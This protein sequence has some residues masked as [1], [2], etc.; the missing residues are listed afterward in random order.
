LFI[1]TGDMPARLIDPQIA[2]ND[3]RERHLAQIGMS[4]RDATH[5]P[6]SV[7]SPARRVAVMLTLSCGH[8]P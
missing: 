3:L 8:T 1:T 4:K 7:C 2:N 5:N 6:P